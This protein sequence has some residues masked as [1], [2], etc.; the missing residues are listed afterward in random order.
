MV[1]LGPG[2]SGFTRRRKSRWEKVREEVEANRRGEY[3]V[4]TWVLFLALLAMIAGVIALVWY[5]RTL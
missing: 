1:D 3:T 4:P 5:G 2:D